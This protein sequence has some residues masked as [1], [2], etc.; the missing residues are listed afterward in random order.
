MPY[1]MDMAEA[2]G[3]PLRH[4]PVYVFTPLTLGGE[5]LRCVLAFRERLSSV[6]VS[7]M[8][9][10]GCTVPIHAG[11]AFALCAAE[12][13]GSAILV[14]QLIDLPVNWSIRICPIDMSSLAMPLGSPEDHLLQYAN[15]EINAFFHGSRWHPAAGSMHTS[16]KQPGAQACV[17]KASLM[18]AGALLG[19]RRF[20]VAGTL[21]LDE[22]FS[23]EQLLYDIEIKDHVQ[24][25]I[26]GIDG[27]CEVD[28]CLQDVKEGV[29]QGSFVGL[30]TTLNAHRDV[31]WYPELFE[32]R[33]LT[34][35]EGNGAP[36]IRERAR[37]TI[38]SL[39]SQHEYELG[40]EL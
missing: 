24:R 34:G 6:R 40:P 23:P 36:T 9:S 30:D 11:D 12:G 21:S 26:S 15:A 17:E 18:T 37:A 20:G 38:Q 29:R 22:V 14:R 27:D 3:N 7:D 25:L 31:Y 4:L 1:V 19:A 16:A 32:R 33:F 35:W 8:T 5:S 28:R 39:L 10:L 13:I 2:V